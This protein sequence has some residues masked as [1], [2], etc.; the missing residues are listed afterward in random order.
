MTRKLLKQEI[1]QALW[2]DCVHFHGHA[3]G[4]LAIGFQ[5]AFLAAEKLS[6][7][8]SQDEELVCISEN[9]ACGVDAIQLLL[10][11][12]AGKGNLLFHLRGKQAFTFYERQGRT[13]IR[14]LLK[15][16]PPLL[17]SERETY[18][19]SRQPSD[20][21]TVMPPRLKLPETAR[22]FDN[23]TCSGCQETTAEP[24]VRL[25]QGQPFCLDCCLPLKKLQFLEETE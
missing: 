8:F 25:R 2:E 5:A 22:L 21:F 15:P 19:L 4:G 11:C 23:L 7:N 17:R 20:Q 24:F 3:C 16:L 9:D 12:S 10:G 18:L 14:L 6:V 1:R 13:G